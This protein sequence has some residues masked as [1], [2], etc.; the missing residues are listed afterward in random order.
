MAIVT[1]VN[2][3]LEI[4]C[5]CAAWEWTRMCTHR[6]KKKMFTSWI[7]TNFLSGK[8]HE[9]FA[10][11]STK[12]AAVKN[13]GSYL[14]SAAELMI[15]V[16]Q[17][18]R[19]LQLI[20]SSHSC[21][22]GQKTAPPGWM[23]AVFCHRWYHHQAFVCASSPSLW[24]LYY[25]TAARAWQAVSKDSSDNCSVRPNRRVWMSIWIRKFTSTHSASKLFIELILQTFLLHH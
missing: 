22:W 19:L 17:C 23:A 12:L 4:K 2:K 21:S 13:T 1:I 25:E 20:S 24:W 3:D 9:F 8:F 15:K 10:S 7:T 5:N 14:Q 11:V 18:P 6:E 16:H